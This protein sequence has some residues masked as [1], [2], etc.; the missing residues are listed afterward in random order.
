MSFLNNVKMITYTGRNINGFAGLDRGTEDIGW[1]FEDESGFFFFLL[2]TPFRCNKSAPER[3]ASAVLLII[4]NRTQLVFYIRLK[5]SRCI[6]STAHVCGK[7]CEIQSSW[8][9]RGVGKYNLSSVSFFVR[10]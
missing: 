6:I 9:S 1:S 8:L 2:E 3:F 4:G 7:N 5:I 10:V